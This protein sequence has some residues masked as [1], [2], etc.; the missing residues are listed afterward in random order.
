MLICSESEL[1][2][3]IELEEVEEVVGCL[4]RGKAAGIDGVV[5]ELL[6][7]GGVWMVKSLW[8]LCGE[9]FKHARVPEEWTKA[10]KVPIKNKGKGDRFEQYRGVTLIS[11]VAKVYGMVLERRL[12]VWCERE[13]LLRDEQ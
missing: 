1:N 2:R 3:D 7:N 5:G 13:G 9:A 4:K 11:V 10:I 12:R 8:V 6:K